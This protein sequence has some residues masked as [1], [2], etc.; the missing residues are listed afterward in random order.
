MTTINAYL[1]FNGTCREAMIFYKN[2]FGGELM[3]QTVSESP[4]ADKMPKEKQQH[5]LHSTL[6]KRDL[7]LLAS[8]MGNEMINGNTI[9]LAADFEFEREIRE[10]FTKLSGGGKIVVPL[11]KTFWGGMLGMLTDKYGYTWSL[12][13]TEE[14]K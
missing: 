6:T 14:K 8:D 12:N 4:Y 3:F 11:D 9:T 5:I 7:L 10:C 1:N 2:C 13:H